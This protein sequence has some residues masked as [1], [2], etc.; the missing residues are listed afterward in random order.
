METFP[1]LHTLQQAAMCFIRQSRAS[2]F[3]Q[4]LQMKQLR[5]EAFA[6]ANMKH[7]RLKPLV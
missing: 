1:Q 4:P 7:K 3:L 2:F 6:C 5:Y